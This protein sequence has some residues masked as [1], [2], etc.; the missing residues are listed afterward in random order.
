MSLDP[1]LCDKLFGLWVRLGF[2]EMICTQVCSV[3]I[4]IVEG[5]I[6]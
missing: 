4:E 6:S 2:T 1:L 3:F 5:D